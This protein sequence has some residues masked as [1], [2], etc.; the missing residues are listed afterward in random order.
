MVAN[1]LPRLKFVNGWVLVV[2]GVA[3]QITASQAR[4]VYGQLRE[5]QEVSHG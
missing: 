5:M 3:L 4:T 2:M 1:A